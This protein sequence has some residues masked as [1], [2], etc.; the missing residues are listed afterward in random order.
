M[1]CVVFGPRYEEVTG[2]WRKPHKLNC[3]YCSPNIV[4][5]IK[6]RRMRWAGHVA[7]IGV[8]RGVYRVLLGKPERRRPLEKPRRRWEDNIKL[9]LQELGCGGINE[10]ELAQNKDSCRAR[11]SMVLNLRGP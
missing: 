1:G 8:S 6:L 2:D 3:L 11:M 5:V 9:Y 7:Y 4:R 10:T